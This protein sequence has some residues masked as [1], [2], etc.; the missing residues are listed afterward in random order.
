MNTNSMQIEKSYS[1]C[2]IIS[3]I[4]LAIISCRSNTEDAKLEIT[5]EHGE[6]LRG[7]EWTCD[8][9]RNELICRKSEWDIKEADGTKIIY[10]IDTVN[11]DENEYFVVFK[12]MVNDQYQITEY[13]KNIC[14]EMRTD[15]LQRVLEHKF[16]RLKF[17]NRTDYFFFEASVKLSGQN[18]K[19][20]GIYVLE[21]NFIFDI[22]IQSLES[23]DQ[24][25]NFQNVLHNL[26][27]KGTLLLDDV[28]EL[29]DF[30]EYD[31]N[32]L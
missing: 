10:K 26:R 2:I 23:K 29:E 15:S 3:I 18:Y 17:K 6:P 24:Y 9:I 25:E 19:N 16:R 27:Y 28:D 22:S 30:V 20:Y 32:E 7:E 31:C 8:S 21:D 14:E 1:F 13:V 5:I 11:Y 4:I 12:Y